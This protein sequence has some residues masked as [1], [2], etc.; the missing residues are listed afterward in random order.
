MSHER[1]SDAATAR[2]AH[3][4]PSQ[5]DALVVGAGIVGLATAFRLS[6]RR[7]GLRITVID[8]EDSIGIHQSGRNSNVIHAGVY[9]RPG[10]LRALLCRRGKAQ[11]EAFLHQHGL[12]HRRCGK[13]I[14]ATRPEEMPR[15]E[16]LAE[17]AAANG[18]HAVRMDARGLRDIEPA[19]AGLAALHVAE[20]GV[21]DYSLVMRR[22]ADLLRERGHAI[23]PG[24][25][26]ERLVDRGDSCIAE[27]TRGDCESAMVIAC[28]GLHSDR[29]ARKAG[30]RPKARIVPFRGEYFELSPEACD[31]VKGLIYPVP[32]P[33]LPFLG[34][35]LTI[36]ANGAVECG[37]NAV[38]A[39]ARE[40]YHFSDVRL[41]DLLETLAYPG[42]W[43]LARKHWRSGL[44]E[45]RRSLD[46]ARFCASLQTL[47]PDI[48]QEHLRK[49][50][51]GVRAQAVAPDGS[52]VDDFLIERRGRMVHVCNAPSPAAT[53]SLAIADAI[54]SEVDQ[55]G[56]LIR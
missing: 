53:A 5:C 15:L 46:P 52:M 18:V 24:C 40:G 34:V 10:S 33:T 12:P 50:P 22:L 6:E 23:V 48:R 21:T 39:F 51:A 29:V 43:R 7:P 31:L 44:D 2:P 55:L 1:T 49:V 41:G 26:L 17:R 11:L 3:A 4:L 47:V 27:T 16:S 38:L 35:H 19:C 30:L 9:Y 25:R 32:D 8:K 54:T 20:S 37:P 13:L 36:T 42:F 45:M 56:P 14:V 28:A